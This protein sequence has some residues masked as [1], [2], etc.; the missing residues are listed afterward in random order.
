M[1]DREIKSL[2]LKNPE[3]GAIREKAIEMGMETLREAG[4]E[5]IAKGT[6]SF[7]EVIRVTQEED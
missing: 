3:A 7:D 2:I 1:V 4:F 6:T 5:K